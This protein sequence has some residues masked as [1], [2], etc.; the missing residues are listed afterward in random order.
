MRIVDDDKII[1]ITEKVTNKHQKA[2]KKLSEKK[3]IKR[4][5]LYHDIVINLLLINQLI[6][7]IILFYISTK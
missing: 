2:F 6:I 1:D 5:T 7:Y 4:K 3:E